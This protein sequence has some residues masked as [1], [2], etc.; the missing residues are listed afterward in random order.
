MSSNNIADSSALFES[1]QN[2]YILTIYARK[3]ETFENIF[4]IM[5][6]K[7]NPHYNYNNLRS[8]IYNLRN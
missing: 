7:N 8:R 6:S 2:Y 5:K 1:L 4:I 3:K